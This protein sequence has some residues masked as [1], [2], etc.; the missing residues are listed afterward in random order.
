[1]I[2]GSII[3]ERVEILFQMRVSL[4]RYVISVNLTG[5]FSFSDFFAARPM[6]TGARPSAPVTGGVWS[7]WTASTNARISTMYD[8]A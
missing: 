1:L 6:T 5:R 4:T 2:T 7:C 8:S 3:I